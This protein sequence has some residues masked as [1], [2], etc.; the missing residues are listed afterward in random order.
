MEQI[1]AAIRLDPFRICDK[2]DM[3]G[4]LKRVST[5]ENQ[6]LEYVAGCD[7]PLDAVVRLYDAVGWS[8]Y[9]KEPDNLAAALGLARVISDGHSICYL[10]D[11][12]VDPKF[13][14]TGL[15]RDL[16]QYV[17]APYAHV[18]QKVLLTDTEQGQKAFYGAIFSPGDQL[19]AAGR[20]VRFRTEPVLLSDQ[21]RR[22]SSG[23]HGIFHG[24]ETRQKTSI[25]LLRPIP[26]S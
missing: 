10:Q 6:T 17:L 8:A 11:V 13:Q 26:A 20:S 12:L 4:V 23:I 15:G 5:V 24:L 1:F 22:V 7:L 9:T 19:A 18:R 14:R 16:V 21:R 3:G 25:S 2:N